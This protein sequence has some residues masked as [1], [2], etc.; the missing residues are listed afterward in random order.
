[1]E[2]RSGSGRHQIVVG[3]AA[4]AVAG[5]EDGRLVTFA[6]G[7]CIALTAWDSELRI[8]GMLHYMLPRP[9][10]DADAGM[11]PPCLYASTGIPRLLRCLEQR[12]CRRD[13]LLLCAAGGAEVIRDPGVQALGQ[14]NR[15][16]LRKA[17]HLE[18]CFLTAEDTGGWT[19]RTMSLDPFSG[20]VRVRTRAGER[21]LWSPRGIP[22]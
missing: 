10:R 18:G 22:Y 19:A 12:G 9:V 1:M 13:R 6:I 4:L 20:D 11:V 8:G 3:I 15:V 5:A 21:V 16:L 17:L 14:Q 2:R 7:S